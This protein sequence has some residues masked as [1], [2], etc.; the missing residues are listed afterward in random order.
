MSRPS[1]LLLG[2]DGGGTSTVARLADA[3]GRVLG[4]G[5]AGPSNIKAVGAEAARSALDRAITSAFADSG[6]AVGPVASTCLGLAGFDRPADRR[7][8]DDWARPEAWAGRSIRVVNDGELVVAAGTPEGWGVGVIAGTGSISVGRGPDGRTARA[9]GWGHIFGD[10]GSAYRVAVEGLRRV[11]RVADGRQAGG[12]TDPDPL[13]R[14]LCEALGIADTSELVSAVYR[15][16]FDRTRIAALAPAV[17]AAAADD[18]SIFAEILEPA[19][20]DL[21][22]MVAAT[23]RSLGLGPGRGPLPLAMA[24]SFL[25]NC[26]AV[27]RVLIHRLIEGGHDVQAAPVAEP[28]EGAL[29]LARKALEP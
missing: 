16:G 24:G 6:L 10:E 23:A 25:L 26:K 17:V 1:P 19:G 5:A 9:G 20:A 2:I 3:E 14:R 8:L 28:V 13:S 29:F 22:R 11:A 4:R 27:S 18:P 12:P 21:A 15:E 7:W